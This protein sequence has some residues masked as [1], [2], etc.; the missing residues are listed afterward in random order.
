MQ[1]QY[2]INEELNEKKIGQ[3]LE[4]LYEGW[5][6]VAESCYGRSYAD[7]PEIDGKIYF[8]AKRRPKEGDF[9]RVKITEVLDYDIIGVA[10]GK[11]TKKK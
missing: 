6:P 11:D 4:V 8:T 5:D 9:V 7:A 3:T 10:V 1:L 2:E